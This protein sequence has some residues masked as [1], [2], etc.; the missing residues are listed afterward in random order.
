MMITDKINFKQPKYVLPAILYPLLLISGYLIFDI[1]DTEPAETGNTLQTTEFLNPELPQARVD[2]NGGIDG[3][4]ESMVKSYGRIQDFSAVENIERNN[5]KDDKEAYESK[6]TEDDLALLDMEADKR[7]EELERLREMQERLRKSAEKGEAMNNDTVSLPLPDED[8]RIARSEQRRKEALAELDKALAEA[9]LQGRKGLEPTPDN[10]DTSVSRPMTT[11]TVT[12][13]NVEVNDN[14]VH[15]SSGLLATSK[16]DCNPIYDKYIIDQSEQLKCIISKIRKFRTDYKISHKESLKLIIRSNQR[17]F[18]I[19]I[20]KK[21]CNLSL[22]E[23][24]DEL[25]ENSY[26]FIEYSSEFFI[27]GYINRQNENLL[28]NIIDRIEYF[29]GFISKIEEKLKNDSFINKAPESI[30]KRE[31][32]KLEDSKSQLL[33]LQEKMRT[34][35]NE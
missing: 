3:K 30:I 7:T 32:Q 20:I 12:D 5:N 17:T 29:K 26:S 1:F 34:I 4:Y 9:R 15:E 10:T 16:W 24:T 6:Y 19:D 35:T 13:R 18:K 11:G 31:K 23:Y 8:G 21:M 28:D 14:I 22:V 2:N 27:T 25:V 33:L